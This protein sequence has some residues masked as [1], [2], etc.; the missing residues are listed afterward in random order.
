MKRCDVHIG[1]LY[2][3][4]V[5]GK[6]VPVRIT[7]ESRYGGWDAVNVETRRAV[8]VRSPQRLRMRLA[9]P[10]VQEGGTEMAKAKKHA[11]GA[12]VKKATQKSAKVEV[13]AE[14]KTC[15]KCGGPLEV[16]KA[17]HKAGKVVYGCPKCDGSQVEASRAEA[18]RKVTEK[19]DLLKRA[20]EAR[21][22]KKRAKAEAAKERAERLGAE[23]PA[24]KAKAPRKPR[25]KGQMSG[26]DAAAKVLGEAGKPLNCKAIVEQALAKG[27]WSPGGKTPAATIYSAILREIQ[28]KGQASRF[29]KAAPGRFALAAPKA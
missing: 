18:H 15:P 22:A 17:D 9:G 6:V 3:A 4:K 12:S 8:R 29:T 23:A 25:A 2:S 26:L 10:S 13:E 24:A 14:A 20:R 21:E 5:S 16:V 27:Y 7:G 11:Q 1:H 28:T 19:T